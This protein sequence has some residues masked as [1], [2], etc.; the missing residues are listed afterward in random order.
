MFKTGIKP[1]W[2]DPK[3]AEGS[4][5]RVELANF[6]DGPVL[7]SVWETLVF[8]MC[9]GKCPH[10]VDGIAGVRLNQKLVGNTLKGYRIEV[11][12]L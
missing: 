2:E 7:Q 3:N 4:E 11:W 9:I 1:E 12:L 6:K 5:F 10:I 8:D